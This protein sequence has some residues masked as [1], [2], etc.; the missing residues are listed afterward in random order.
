MN[1][2]ERHIIQ[3]A[4]RFWKMVSCLVTFICVWY[5]GITLSISGEWENE[6]SVIPEVRPILAGKDCDSFFPQ[7][8]FLLVVSR[9]FPSWKVV[10]CDLQLMASF[11]SSAH[12]ALSGAKPAFCF[13]SLLPLRKRAEKRCRYNCKGVSF[14]NLAQHCRDFPLFGRGCKWF[15]HSPLDRSSVV[16]Q[17]S[18]EDGC[19]FCWC[20]PS[21][22]R[23]LCPILHFCSSGKNTGWLFSIATQL[24]A[25]QSKQHVVSRERKVHLSEVWK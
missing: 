22:W 25:S 17:G 10:L 6:C 12:L 16:T 18:G 14:L 11:L 20:Q 4:K 13:V 3:I 15:V 1:M 8:F 21:T 9:T 2:K 19:F 7:D 23:C 5:L 24:L